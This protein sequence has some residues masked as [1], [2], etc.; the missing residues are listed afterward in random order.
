MYM[1]R[2]SYSLL[3]LFLLVNCDLHSGVRLP[4]QLSLLSVGGAVWECL[5]SQ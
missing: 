2:G 3:I 4:N 1:G 5:A